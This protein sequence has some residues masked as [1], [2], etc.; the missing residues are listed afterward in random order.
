MRPLGLFW[1]QLGKDARHPITRKPA[2]ISLAMQPAWDLKG[3]QAR[4][5]GCSVIFPPTKCRSLKKLFLSHRAVRMKLPPAEWSVSGLKS[6]N[7]FTWS[8]VQS[9]VGHQTH[10]QRMLHVLPCVHAGRHR[11]CQQLP[12]TFYFKKWP[13]CKFPWK[14]TSQGTEHVQLKGQRENKKEKYNI[15]IYK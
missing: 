8:S 12:S 10:C 6:T 9:W 5:S 11:H 2:C 3:D 14:G 7:R 13:H 15:N 4:L 1:L